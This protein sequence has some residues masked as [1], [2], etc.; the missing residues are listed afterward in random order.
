MDIATRIRK[1]RNYLQGEHAHGI[2]CCVYLGY[3]E[4]IEFTSN[5]EYLARN[6]GVVSHNNTRFDGMPV[7]R[8]A[9]TSHFNVAEMKP[10]I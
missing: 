9:N 8:V 5:A 4:W 10:M 3:S 6:A 2:A 1:A 7:Y